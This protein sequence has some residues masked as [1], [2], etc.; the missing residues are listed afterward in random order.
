MP[1]L[2]HFRPPVSD[3][4]QG[5]SFHAVWASSLADQL[6]RIVPQQFRVQ[7][8][9]ILGGG[10]EIDIAALKKPTESNGASTPLRSGWQPLTAAESCPAIF[11]ERFEVL[12]YRMFGGR[13]LVGAIELVSPGN[14][15]RDEAKAAFANKVVS[16]LHEGVSVIVMDVVTELHAN[17]HNDIARLMRFPDTLQFPP[18]TGL[19]AAAYR[20]VIR[21]DEPELDVW[22]YPL[23]VGDPLPTVP[24]RL[25]ADYFV[26]VDFEAAYTD[27]R[28]RRL[29]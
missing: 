13:Q 23:A 6:T 21:N 17:L 9:L 2:D 14:K 12:V 25:I 22:T 15:D 26:P 28:Q 3:D 16:Y 18:E 5:N 29:I 8:H 7:E 24:L 1:L 10:V 4:I 19:Y 11:P 20:P 27:A